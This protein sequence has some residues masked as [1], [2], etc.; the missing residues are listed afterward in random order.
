MGGEG[1]GGRDIRRRPPSEGV[2]LDGEMKIEDMVVRSIVKVREGV[3]IVQLCCPG[4]DGY[5]RF[6]ELPEG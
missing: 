4:P 5:F 1:G 3:P 6:R 2:W